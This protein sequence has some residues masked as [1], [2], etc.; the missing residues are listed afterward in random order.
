MLAETFH[1][2]AA[3]ARNVF[4][5]WRTM[6]LVAIVYASLLAALYFFVA[7]KEA[8]IAQVI[9]TFVLAIAAPIL[10]F[11]LQ[12]M[13]AN[14]SG[15]P[16]VGSFLKKSLASFWK[17][18]LISLPLIAL[19]VLIAYLLAKAQNHFGAGINNSAEPL[20]PLATMAKAR[21]AAKP[22][23]WKAAMISSVR[24]L[25]FGLVLPL[26]AIHLWLATVREGLGVAIRKLHR[27]LSRA[28]A[29]QSVLIYMAG[30]LIFGIAPYLL[31]FK[32]TP[33]KNA[34][35]EISFLVIRLAIVFAL[36]LFGWAITVRALSFLSRNS[37]NNPA[38]EA[39]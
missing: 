9:L 5:N 18:L 29:P 6:L 25:V 10:F 28:F 34:W 7:V 33:T 17:L 39:A 19:A 31:L 27:H 32:A 11:V 30:F 26:A 15:E 13:V 20:R 2:I 3:A 14:D 37:L 38:N 21:E 16:S 8:S 35:L 36:T 22:I 1:S 4:T 24:Y 12:A 23:D